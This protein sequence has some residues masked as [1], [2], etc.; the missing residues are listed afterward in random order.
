MPHRI[1]VPTLVQLDYNPRTGRYHNAHTKQFVKKQFVMDALQRQLDQSKEAVKQAGK[2]LR[3][4]TIDTTQ[5]RDRM[6]D[7][8]RTSHTIQY[9]VGKGG[10]AGMN[11]ADYGRIGSILKKQYKILNNFVSHMQETYASPQNLDG[12]FDVRAGMYVQTAGQT[13]DVARRIEQQEAGKREE[14]RILHP[15]EHCEDC[16]EAAERDWQPIGTLPAIG[17]SACHS[18]CKCEFQYR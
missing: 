15:A 2:E 9:V 7:E 13:Y 3:A 17:D 1:N 11:D 16:I 8:L 5:W 4:G 18:G 10:W 12:R 14:R 6:V